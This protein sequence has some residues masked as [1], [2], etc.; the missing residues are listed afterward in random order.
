[1]VVTQ[2]VC[3]RGALMLRLPSSLNRSSSAVVPL[4]IVLTKHFSDGN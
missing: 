3:A 2:H 1:V 4:F